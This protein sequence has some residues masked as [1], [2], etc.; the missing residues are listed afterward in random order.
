MK[1]LLGVT[2]FFLVSSVAHADI[3]VEYED[4]HVF[5]ASECANNYKF[6]YFGYDHIQRACIESTDAVSV[7]KFIAFSRDHD[8]FG[9][10]RVDSGVIRDGILYADAIARVQGCEGRH[11][12]DFF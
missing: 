5:W 2:L 8:C 3:A 12:Q 1:K 6:S 7:E 11:D 10:V 4:G 9:Q